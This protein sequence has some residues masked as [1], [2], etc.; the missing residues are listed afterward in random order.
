MYDIPG[1]EVATLFNKVEKADTQKVEFNPVH[2]SRGI[3]YASGVYF[4]RLQA[5]SFVETKKMILSK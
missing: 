4:Y 1:Y 3:G 2:L 5:R